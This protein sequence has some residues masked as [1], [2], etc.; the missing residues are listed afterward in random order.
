MKRDGIE[1]DERMALLEEIT[2]PKP[3]ADLLTQSFEV[4]ASSQPWVRDFELSPKSVVRDMFERAMSFAEYVSFYQLSRSEGLV[5]RYLSDADRA[6]RQTVPADARTDEL[7]DIIEWLGELVRQVDSS[8]VDEWSALID[9][10]AVLPEDGAPVVPPAPPSILTNERAFTVLVRNELFR[11][12]QLAA[13]QDDDALVALDP[14]VGPE[15]LDRY[16]DEHDEILTGGPARSPRLCVIDTADAA[17]S[18]LW[19]VE[20][21]IDDPAGDHDWRIRAEVDLAASVEEGAAVV[22][23]I[24]LV[25]L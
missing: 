10:T 25:R 12:V 14:E 15:A 23:V 1:Y 24:E 7:R 21:T 3:L 6:I 17:A 13:L 19:R 4:F 11:R 9:P 5:L 22:R 18:G 16:Y 2:Y 8:L 20:Q